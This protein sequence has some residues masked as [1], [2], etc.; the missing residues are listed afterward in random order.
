MVEIS[1]TCDMELRQ[2]FYQRAPAMSECL[3]MTEVTNINQILLKL[4][5]VTFSESILSLYFTH[6]I[7]DTKYVREKIPQR[8]TLPQ[9]LRENKGT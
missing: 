8:N 4:I 3:V 2:C 1:V 7:Q 9:L 6:K 5:K